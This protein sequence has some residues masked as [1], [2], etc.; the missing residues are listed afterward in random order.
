VLARGSQTGVYHTNQFN[1]NSSELPGRLA[2]DQPPV[3]NTRLLE[4]FPPSLREYVSAFYWGHEHSTA[5]F[6]R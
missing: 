1:I 5:I 4:Q 6:D 2:N 3:A